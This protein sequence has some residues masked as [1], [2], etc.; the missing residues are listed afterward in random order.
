MFL[1]N[2]NKSGR[3]TPGLILLTTLTFSGCAGKPW[4]IPLDGDRY[5]E[6][7]QLVD[8]LILDN[9]S[10]G[11]SLDGDLA[12]FYADPLEKKALGGYLRFSM[13]G[14]FKFVVTN[15]FGQTVLAIAGDQKSYQAVSV[16]EQKYLAGSI[17]SFGLRHDIPAEI[18]GGPWGEWLTGRNL[19]PGNTISTIREDKNSRGLWISFH[20]SKIEPAGM[21]HLLLEP[22]SK[23]PLSRILENG[24][25]RIV[26]EVTYGDWIHQGEC[27]QPQEINITGLDY[28]IDIRLKFSNV[29]LTGDAKQYTLPVP[30]GYIQQHMP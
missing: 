7:S 24:E 28:G 25:G 21:S 30:P 19:R 14:S 27:Q 20:H 4:T 3:L 13:P 16:P 26:A 29:R 6:T 12:L 8:S 1:I 18:L 10:C 15:P 17:R 5:N 9:R 11:Q 2:S 22:V 23:L